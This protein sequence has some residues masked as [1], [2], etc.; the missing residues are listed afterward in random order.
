VARA[1]W[2]S[3]G[4]PLP[5]LPLSART[6]PFDAA[7]PGGPCRHPRCWQGDVAPCRHHRCR[8]PKLIHAKLPMYHFLRYSFYSLASSIVQ[9]QYSK[10]LSGSELAGNGATSHLAGNED[11]GRAHPAERRLR[12]GNGNGGRGLPAL[13]QAARAT[14]RL[15]RGAATRRGSFLTK[16]FAGGLF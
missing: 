1:A 7:R 14:C 4:R 2:A 15:A 11:G 9:L 5:P 16:N 3:A 13:A 10:L 6:S 12:A 8:H